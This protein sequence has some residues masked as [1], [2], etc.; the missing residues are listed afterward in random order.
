[1]MHALN[2]ISQWA[3]ALAGITLTLIMGITVAD[4]ILRS[5]G[6]P[7][8]G[9]FELVAYV[10]SCGHWFFHPFHFLG[11]GA[12]LRGFFC[13]EGFPPVRKGIHLATRCMGLGLFLLIGWNLI[14]WVGDLSRSGEVS[15]TLQMPFYPVVYGVGFCCLSRPWFCWAIS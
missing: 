7:I 13:D 11:E 5:C 6:R 4:V 1:M 15:P 8:V 3:N 9:I 10:R 14:K 2:R 12:H